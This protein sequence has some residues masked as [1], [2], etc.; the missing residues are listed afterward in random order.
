MCL[1]IP[2]KVEIIEGTV[3]TVDIMGVKNRVAIDMVKDVKL[4]DYLMIHAG[5]AIEKI[6]EAEAL[7]TIELFHE[8][9]GLLGKEDV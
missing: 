4:G 2:G 3:A 5:Y 8:L 1:A 9:G 7:Q 6:D